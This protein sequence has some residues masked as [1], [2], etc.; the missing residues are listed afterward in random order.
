MSLSGKKILVAISG[1]IAA[2]KMASFVR[3]LIK[4]N[5]EVKI[6]MTPAAQDFITP[7]T[8]STLSKNPVWS[9]VHSGEGWNN[10]VE[11]G[12][13]ADALL[14]APAT[15]NTLAKMANGLCDNLLLAVYL[16][17]RCPVFIAPAMDL[18]MWAHPATQYNVERL[19]GFG[20]HL[21]PVEDGELASGLVGKGRMAEPETMLQHLKDFFQAATPQALLGKR[22]LITSGATQEA[23]DPVRFISNHSTG[24]MG[25]ALAEQMAKAGA[26][27]TL[28]SAQSAIL[29][30]AHPRITIVPIVSANDLHQAAA[31]YFATADITILAAAVADYTPKEQAKHKIKKKDGPLTIALTRTVDVAATLG[32]QKSV[33]QLLIG[34]A[35]E[36]NNALE[37]ALGKLQRKNFDAIVLNDLSDDG[38][39]FGHTT[40]KVTIITSNGQQTSYPLKSKQAVALDILE[41]VIE[42]STN[43]S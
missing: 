33:H 36:T 24:R 9:D 42:L 26:T 25:A 39:G 35:L 4:A 15:A 6:V 34:F 20:N 2:Y 5:A 31:Q 14:I 41:K 18:D 1:S 17:S 3:L 30:P 16:S 13:W 37:N 22:V 28:V 23:I 7:L 29:P 12:L 40:N 32:Q 27:V 38:A 10:H 19:Q 11:L 8:L 43:A 21:L